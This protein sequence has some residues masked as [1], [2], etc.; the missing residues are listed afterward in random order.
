[1]FSKI[2]LVR[3]CHQIPVAAD[4]VS[5]TSSYE[6]HSVSKTQLLLGASVLM[7]NGHRLQ[8]SR[9]LS[10]PSI[11]AMKRMAAAKFVWPGIRKQVG[12]WAKTCLRCQAANV[13]QQFCW[14]TT[15]PVDQFVP[16]TCRFVHIHV[17][18]VS[19]LP[20]LQ[21]SIAVHSGRQIH[22]VAR[23]DP[24]CRCTNNHVREG[25]CFTL[26]CPP[27]CTNRTYVRQRLTVHF[28]TVGDFVPTERHTSAQ[29]NRVP[30]SV[31]RN[32][33]TVPSSSEICFDGSPQWP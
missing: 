17:D 22:Q 11:Q 24:T 16:Q 33:G 23:S 29:E 27:W 32:R 8:R 1:M 20:P 21:N 14:H 10:H 13:H 5:K 15:A 3:G 25:P 2:D 6:H 4:D 19:P 7:P 26:D 18:I 28:R 30:T 12:I 9:V 31:E